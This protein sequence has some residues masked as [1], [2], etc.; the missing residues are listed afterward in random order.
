[1]TSLQLQVKYTGSLLQFLS[2]FRFHFTLGMAGFSSKSVNSFPIPNFFPDSLTPKQQLQDAEMFRC[3]KIKL[4]G[5]R[6]CFW[7]NNKSQ[8]NLHTSHHFSSKSTNSL[9]NIIAYSEAPRCHLPLTTPSSPQNMKNEAAGIQKCVEFEH[10]GVRRRPLT[11][12][13]AT[14]S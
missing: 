1:M 12:G 7:F 9:S 13:S 2:L 3:H 4:E 8:W 5:A 6:F 10:T 14:K 11:S